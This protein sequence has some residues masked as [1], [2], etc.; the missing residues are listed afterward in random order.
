[1]GNSEV[2]TVTD[3]LF[4]EHFMKFLLEN[5]SVGR[6]IV[7]KGLLASRARLAAKRARE[8][9]R[10]KGALEISNLPGKLADCSS[11]DPENANC[12]SSKEIRPADQLSKVVIESFKPSCLFV[13]K[14]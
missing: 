12:S 13:G 8:V 6:Q 1:M 10:R 9:T 7:E 2:R 4:S 5:P 3:R 14:S 11:N